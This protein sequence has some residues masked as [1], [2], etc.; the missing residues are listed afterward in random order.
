MENKVELSVRA[1][2]LGDG[3][4]LRIEAPNPEY[5][6]QEDVNEAIRLGLVRMSDA[7]RELISLRMADA[8][9]AKLGPDTLIL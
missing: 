4:L 7:L 5:L 2:P 8:A 9:V 3:F 6:A 1:E